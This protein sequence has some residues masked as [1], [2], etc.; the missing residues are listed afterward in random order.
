MLPSVEKK[1]NDNTDFKKLVLSAIRSCIKDYLDDFT[2]NGVS[3]KAESLLLSQ[4]YSWT[5]NGDTFINSFSNA[6]KSQADAKYVSGILTLFDDTEDD[7]V[8]LL[9]DGITP[10]PDVAKEELKT[11]IINNNYLYLLAGAVA[12]DYSKTE[13]DSETDT[14]S[15]PE[16]TTE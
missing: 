16:T 7:S 12:E 5:K 10:D 13:Y 11:K 8:T 15:V 6:T 1:M 4:C 2:T 9:D 3:N 14:W